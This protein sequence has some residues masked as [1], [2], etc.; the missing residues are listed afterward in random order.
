MRAASRRPTPAGA[1]GALLV[2]FSLWILQGFLLALLVA[3]VTAV[4]SWPLY[5]RCATRLPAAPLLFTVL[6]TLLFVAPFVFALGALL[7]EAQALLV[8]LAAADEKGIAPPAWLR[9]LPLAGGWLA[10]RWE[11]R[12]A[13]SGSL[14]LWVEHADV[15]AWARW[16]GDFMA[17]QLF[18]VFCTVIALFF[19]YRD[20][21]ALSR[22]LR[23]LLRDRA[24][25][26]AG[27]QVELAVRSVRAA[28][29]S[30]LVVALFAG[31]ASGIGYALAGVARPATWGAI[32]G[33]FALVPFLGYAAVLAVALQLAL[34]G[35]AGGAL[36]ASA[37]G[38][39]VLF[40]GDKFLRP[41]LAG[42]GTRLGFAWLLMGCLGGF[43]ALGLVGLVV[44]PVVLTLAGELWQRLGRRQS[45][46][47]RDRSTTTPARAADS[48]VPPAIP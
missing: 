25:A 7:G 39:A 3:C 5:R 18:I 24:G 20:G 17:R 10:E 44:G 4:A 22:R 6:V 12:L 41:A 16:L 32:T 43:E 46:P 19:L 28:V 15:L 21:E 13:H 47:I 34:G 29:S 2:L 8:Q 26:F 31:V 23:G 9:E 36:A 35:A 1:Y 42:K 33:V 30:M 45:R 14:S 40:F 11:R 48:L 27:L 37:I 38:A